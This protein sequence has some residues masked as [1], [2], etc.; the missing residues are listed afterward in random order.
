MERQQTSGTFFKPADIQMLQMLQRVLQ[1]TLPVG[2]SPREREAHAAKLV[3]LFKS[4][5]TSEDKLVSAVT[6]SPGA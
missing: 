4:G 1:T 5:L 3:T 2:A 6:G